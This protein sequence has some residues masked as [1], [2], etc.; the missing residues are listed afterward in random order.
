MSKSLIVVVSLLV[1]ANLWT[2]KNLQMTK[3]TLKMTSDDLIEVQNTLDNLKSKINKDLLDLRTYSEQSKN[4]FKT[5]NKT[6]TKL[7]L[8]SKREHI[9]KAK[10]GLVGKQITK[11]F[12][13]FSRSLQEVTE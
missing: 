2:F 5:L 8:D 3:E 12:N 10:P 6:I 7:E 9:V 13:E 1:I 11:S 4:D